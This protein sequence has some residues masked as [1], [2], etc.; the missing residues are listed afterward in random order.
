MI[1]SPSETDQ[2]VASKPVNLNETF[3]LETPSKML[4]EKKHKLQETVSEQVVEV[5]FKKLM[6]DDEHE[7]QLEAESEQVTEQPGQEPE[8][9]LESGREPEPLENT[10]VAVAVDNNEEEDIEIPF[11]MDGGEVVDTKPKRL[12]EAKEVDEKES[13]SE[14]VKSLGIIY[15][16]SDLINSLQ[17]CAGS[18]R[19]GLAFMGLNDPDSKLV[20]DTNEYI[21]ITNLFNDIRKSVQAF[22]DKMSFN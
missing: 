11:S 9:K 3:E 18:L 10:E 12:Q 5:V 1:Y 8:K 14:V 15:H 20:L 13:K 16:N 19:T 4:L 21:K 17:G 2:V 6:I 7:S 22:E